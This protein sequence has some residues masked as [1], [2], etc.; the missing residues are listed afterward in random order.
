MNLIE[1]RPYPCM[2]C[3]IDVR[4]NIREFPERNGDILIEC[5]WICPQ[6]G[7][8]LRRDEELIKKPNETNK[9]V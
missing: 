6:C 7:Q 1:N 4:G 3:H 8:L 5:S 9:K 2:R